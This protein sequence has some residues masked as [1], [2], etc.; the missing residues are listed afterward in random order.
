MQA[1]HKRKPN[2]LGRQRWSRLKSGLPSQCFAP[3]QTF[4]AAL[5]R[6]KTEGTFQVTAFRHVAEYPTR[7]TDSGIALAIYSGAA[8]RESQS[9]QAKTS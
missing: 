3:D 7:P 9:N 5:E 6:S 4:G 2:D 1:N 8:R